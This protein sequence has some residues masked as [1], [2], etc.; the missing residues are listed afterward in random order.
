MKLGAFFFGGVE[1][2]DAGA[3]APNPMDRYYDNAAVLGR[4]AEVH[5]CRGRRR[6]A[7]LRQLLDHR[8]PLPVRGL[9][10]HPQR[11]PRHRLDRRPHRAHPARHDVQRGA[12]VEPA[13][14]RR[15][16]RHH[17][18]PQRWPRHPRRRPRH[19]AAR[20]PAPQRPARLHRLARQPR[21]GR[22][23]RRRTAST[24][25]SRWRSSAPRSPASRFS[26]Q[27]QVLPAPRCPASPTAARPCSS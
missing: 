17:A 25:R 12:A 20:D 4:D 2:T 26:L 27:R 24:S 22:R 10:G 19:R 11:H 15:G 5:R 8:A 13:A 3:G 18:Q 7:R 21:P 23:R 1:M 9:R 14:P 16:L 6:Q